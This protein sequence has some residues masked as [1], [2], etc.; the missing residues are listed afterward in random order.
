M[1]NKYIVVNNGKIKLSDI[2]NDCTNLC[3]PTYKGEP[4]SSILNKICGTSSSEEV[5]ITAG[6]GISVS[7]AYPDFTIINTQPDQV[8][9]LT[10][11]SNITI[12]GTYPDFTI[13]AS[14]GGI[15]TDELIKVS[16]N[17]TTAGYLNGKLVSGTGIILTENNNGGNETLTV[18]HSDTSSV[19]NLDTT[20][21]Q[22]I[23]TLTFDTFGHVQ[24]VTTRDLTLA[25][26]GFTGGGAIIDGIYRFDTST[27]AADP[28]SGD[29][30]FNNATYASVTEIYISQFSDPGTDVGNILGTLKAGDVIYIQDRNDATKWFRADINTTPTDNGAWWT[31]PVTYVNSGG[32]LFGNNQE[33]NV[34]AILN[35]SSGS[36]DTNFANTDL[37]QTGNRIYDGNSFNYTLNELGNWTFDFQHTKDFHVENAKI[38]FIENDYTN[39]GVNT[40]GWLD[41]DP[42]FAEMYWSQIIS[43]STHSGLISINT[44]G[45]TPRINIKARRGALQSNID[46]YRDEIDIDPGSSGI[47]KILNL[48]NLTT[49]DVLIGQNNASDQVGY[50]TI[51]SGLSLSSGVLSATGGGSGTVNTGAQFKAAYYPT[52]GTVVDDWIGVNFGQTNINT[53]I[54]SQATT[55]VLLEMNLAASQ[56]ANAYT[57]KNSGGTTLTQITKDGYL[58]LPAGTTTSLS[59]TALNLNNIGL[60]EWTSIGGLLMY[61]SSTLRFGVSGQFGIFFRDASTFS[62]DVGNSSVLGGT[63][64]FR[65]TAPAV[66]TMQLGMEVTQQNMIFKGKDNAGTNATAFN[67]TLQPGAGTG[68]STLGGN[69]IVQTPDTTGSGT[70]VQTYTSKF[71]VQ[72]TGQLKA[73]LYGSGTFTGTAAK[74]LAVTSAGLVIEENAPT[75]SGGYTVHTVTTTPYTVAETSGKVVLLV[76]TSAT[77]TN[78]NATI[79][80]PTAVGNTSEVV[81]KQILAANVITVDPDGTEE[82][83]DASTYTGLT[84]INESISIINDNANWFII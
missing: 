16:A 23:D 66:G 7:G 67:L 60:A 47:F 42:A 33:L 79:N 15:G 31:I 6:T 26:L 2:I 29:L 12:T 45:T 37:T 80:L 14:G 38:F 13:T 40:N 83:D 56:T 24:T 20:G 53:Q 28:G 5:T 61:E 73:N 58:R 50:V 74:W 27:V 82:I 10:E 54:N 43:G 8:V 52:A 44:D 18:A 63:N 77:G 41:W 4:L 3:V 22:V 70:T 9:T 30:R 81:I 48:S 32:T 64:R 39:A 69:F 65:I 19:S 72:K 1:A 17:D 21:A 62:F 35:S 25:D 68:N 57:L 49:Q 78:G 59:T 34:I 75:G 84:N 11:G 71:E 46:L 76:D 55:E 36:A 51:G